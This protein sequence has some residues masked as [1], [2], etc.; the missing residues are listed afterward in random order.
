MLVQYAALNVAR[1]SSARHVLSGQCALLGQLRDRGLDG[2][3]Y[4][5]GLSLVPCSVTVCLSY[6][7]KSKKLSR[8]C[9]AD[10]VSVTRP[11]YGQRTSSQIGV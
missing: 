10:S 3:R 11:G 6:M 5:H 4:E 7:P 2:S 1:I 8:N 9:R